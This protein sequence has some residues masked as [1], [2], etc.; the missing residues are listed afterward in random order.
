MKPRTLIIN[1]LEQTNSQ[2]ISEKLLRKKLFVLQYT[3]IDKVKIF[4]VSL[5]KVALQ[6]RKCSEQGTRNR[7]QRIFRK[8][9]TIQEKIDQKSNFF[10][11]SETDIKLPFCSSFSTF[12]NIFGVLCTQVFYSWLWVRVGISHLCCE[13]KS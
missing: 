5:D 13:I 8:V 7:Q 3:N 1:E 12:K 6:T 4:C 11:S 9:L 10:D 2:C